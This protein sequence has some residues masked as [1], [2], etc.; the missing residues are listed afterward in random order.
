MTWGLCCLVVDGLRDCLDPDC[1]SSAACAQNP[2][3]Q[4][5][6]DPA[7]ILLQKPKPSSTASFFKKMKFLIDNNSIQKET[8][9]NAFN[10]TWVFCFDTNIPKSSPNVWKIYDSFFILISWIDC[11]LWYMY[12]A[13]RWRKVDNEIKFHPNFLSYQ[14][15]LMIILSA[16]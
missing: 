16:S 4:T 11:L 9:K 3:C 8:S 2:F 10:E 6:Q 5:V 12:N 14:R 15:N 13:N 7:E 1:C